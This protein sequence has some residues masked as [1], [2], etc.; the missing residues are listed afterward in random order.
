MI[1]VVVAVDGS[2]I[3]YAYAVV[4]GHLFWRFLVVDE[5]LELGDLRLCF[6]QGERLSRFCHF[7]FP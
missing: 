2:H 7:Q 4:F 1:M 3:P 5:L 6:L